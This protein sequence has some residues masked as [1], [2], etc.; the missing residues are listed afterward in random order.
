VGAIIVTLPWKDLRR[1]AVLLAAA[2]TLA[3]CCTP[4]AA[5]GTAQEGTGSCGAYYTIANPP[6]GNNR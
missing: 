1:V 2:G 4:V 3:A 5:P 6:A